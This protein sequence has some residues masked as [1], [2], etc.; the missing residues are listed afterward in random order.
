M[1]FADEDAMDRFE[2]IDPAIRKYVTALE[3]KSL[4]ENASALSEGPS[5]RMSVR[6]HWLSCPQCREDYSYALSV[7]EV[8]NQVII[9]RV[10][11]L[12]T[13]WSKQWDTET[14]GVG[15]TISTSIDDL[16]YKVA[17]LAVFGIEVQDALSFAVGE[18]ANFSTEPDPIRIP[19]DRVPIS[20]CAP[21][22]R[23]L[24]A[25]V[26]GF[27]FEAVRC[28]DMLIPPH[29]EQIGPARLIPPLD[30]EEASEYDAEQ[31]VAEDQK[32]SFRKALAEVLASKIGA[33]IPELYEFIRVSAAIQL[34]QFLELNHEGESQVAEVVPTRIPG[35]L[36]HDGLEA[37]RSQ[38]SDGFDSLKAGQM[39]IIRLIEQNGRSAAAFEP[40]IEAQLGGLYRRLNDNTKRQLQV[41]EY[42]YS[43]NKSEPN[44]SHGSV[45]NIAL[46]YENELLFEV[47][48]PYLKKKIREGETFYDG[49][50]NDPRRAMLKSG[51]IQKKNLGLSSF[52]WYLIKDQNLRIWAEGTKSL[53]VRL[54]VQD[55]NWIIPKRDSAAHELICRLSAADEVRGWALND[56]GPFLHLHPL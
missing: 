29:E 21:L 28:H 43:I 7:L 45:M 11:G 35:S 6:L 16:A 56:G 34:E 46:A 23:S 37:L 20:R 51:E 19:S 1:N 12:L 40:A 25:A 38:Q 31:T 53:N 24:E 10:V 26:R 13:F 27:V 4:A 14:S 54:I 36:K 50:T 3:W 52:R 33:Q 5:T 48:W 39:E 42:V 2:C 41:A 8:V 17:G 9:D 30:E 47:M 49:G 55:L 15:S 18:F 22:I 44:Y 32:T